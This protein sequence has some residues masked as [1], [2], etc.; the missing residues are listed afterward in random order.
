[1]V[2][3]YVT[4]AAAKMPEENYAFRP[5]PE[6]RTF[7]QLVGHLAQAREPS[8]HDFTDALRQFPLG[9]RCLP[10]AHVAAL[11]EPAPLPLRVIPTAPM[12]VTDPLTATIAGIVNVPAIDLPVPLKVHVLAEALLAS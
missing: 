5:A 3:G 11:G 2:K 8:P 1:M 12:L 7:A 9:D 4:R 10:V 6:V